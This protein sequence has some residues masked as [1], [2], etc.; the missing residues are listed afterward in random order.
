MDGD[1]DGAAEAL[2]LQRPRELAWKLCATPPG[3]E[4]DERQEPRRGGCDAPR[5]SRQRLRGA[6]ACARARRARR[7]TSA[8]GQSFAAIAVP[9]RSAASASRSRS[10][11]RERKHRERRRPEVEARQHHR[12]S[13]SGAS[14]TSTSAPPCVRPARSHEAR[15]QHRRREAAAERHQTG[16]PAVVSVAVALVAERRQDEHR[17][18]GR[19]VL[20]PEVAVRNGWPRRSRR[21]S[22][23][24]TP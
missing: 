4:D 9:S 24:Y 21:R 20:E 18:G 23:L 6:H 19:R 22:C 16:E 17:Q 7:G 10:E 1:E 2:E 8:A 11:R 12:P 14:A 13:A 15:A 3:D 5:R